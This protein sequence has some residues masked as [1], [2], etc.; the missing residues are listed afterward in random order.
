M[1]RKV[2]I[3]KKAFT[4]LVCLFSFNV[5]FS[6]A[7]RVTINVDPASLVPGTIH[8]PVVMSGTEVGIWSVLIHYN[9]SVLTYLNTTA[10]VPSPGGFFGSVGNFGGS[11]PYSPSESLF[12]ASFLYA[13]GAPG[14]TYSN[15]TIFTINFTYTGGDPQL[16][17]KYPS[18]GSTGNNVSYVFANPYTSI[19]T[20]TIWANPFT[21]G[22]IGANQS[23]CGNR[24]PDQLT[25]VAPTGGTLPYTYQWQSSTDNATFFDIP[26][27]TGIN[28]Q[29]GTLTQTTYYHQVQTDGGIQGTRTTNKVTITVTPDFTATASNNGP[30]CVGT[31]LHL[32]GGP[33]GMA[34]YA[35]T[36]PNGFTSNLQNPSIVNAG[37][38][39]AG[40]YSLVVT[41]G[42]CVSTAP[43]TIVEIK[44]LPVP[45]ISGD[46]SV[47]LSS[48]QIVYTT[49][50][51]MTNYN[52]A[53]SSGG[54]IISSAGSNSVTVAWNTPGIQYISVSYTS[55]FGCA[56]RY[57]S[58]LAVKVKSVP[59]PVRNLVN[60]TI[61][62]GQ[63]VCSDA[64]QI[65]TLAGNGTTYLVQPG[66][67]VT[68]IAGQNIV[69]LPG[70][71][72][73]SGAHLH[74]YITTVCEYCLI[75][76]NSL[77]RN[78]DE[79]TKTSLEEKIQ[80]QLFSVYPNPTSGSITLELKDGVNPAQVEV[81][82]YN[83]V[84]KQ[85]FQES[86]LF[87]NKTILSLTDQQPGLYMMVISSPG[88]IE[89]IKIVKK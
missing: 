67:D 42:T 89:R 34:S 78:N 32:T 70:V 59:Q 41:N 30:I 16:Y 13:D 55:P 82:I 1:K 47:C 12:K 88:L 46:T 24:T 49:E 8:V 38:A 31:T 50:S 61:S 22:S 57:P 39:A 77:V 25:G 56:A 65:I 51:G 69:F 45:S 76:T 19:N 9:S 6:Q 4:V 48:A 66:G 84:G 21:A 72:V 52:W 71:Q 26:S 29:P 20:G 43:A 3:L 60:V 54:V 28:Y 18:S 36:G 80:N 87:F 83:M 23:I 5:V 11:P 85:I 14:A 53:V 62:S 33:S 35:W 68:L 37:T 86:S 79:E 44:P 40:P 75:Q 2:Q 15:K 73:M 74:A 10:G 17:F 64:S 7:P 81:K 63:T 27:A 58:I